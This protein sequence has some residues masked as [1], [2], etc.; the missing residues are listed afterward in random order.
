LVA[1]GYSDGITLWDWS[2][3]LVVPAAIAA[4]GL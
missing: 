3:L 1:I 2:K 4:G